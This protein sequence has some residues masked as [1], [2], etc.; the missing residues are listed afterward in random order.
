MVDL[1]TAKYE[2]PGSS[3]HTDAHDLHPVLITVSKRRWRRIMAHDIMTSH[4]RHFPSFPQLHK[5]TKYSHYPYRT[6]SYNPSAKPSSIEQA[7]ETSSLSYIYI[8]R[9]H[10]VDR[11]P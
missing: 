6:H 3:K 4:L 10:N 11:R 5:A 1:F 9:K 2:C 7:A 8:H